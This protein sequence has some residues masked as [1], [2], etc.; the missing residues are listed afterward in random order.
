MWKHAKNSMKELKRP[1][2]VFY[3]G[4]VRS[5]LLKTQ[6]TSK[7]RKTKTWIR[8]PCRTACSGLS[9]YVL[10]MGIKMICTIVFGPQSRVKYHCQKYVLRGHVHGKANRSQNYCPI[11][12]SGF[13]T[14]SHP[15][16]GLHSSLFALFLRFLFLWMWR[17]WW[18]HD[19]DVYVHVTW[20][21]NQEEPSKKFQKQGWVKFL[22]LTNFTM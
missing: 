22:G 14:W 10:H 4:Y 15:L 19:R 6:K 2:S 20:I 7:A 13:L 8:I 16:A 21:A 17:G 3:A 5:S 9:K 1:K 11:M 12:S 18:K